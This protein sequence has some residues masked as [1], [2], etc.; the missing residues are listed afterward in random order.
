MIADRQVADK[1]I[2]NSFVKDFILVL[3]K[4]K[5]RYIL[6]SGFVAISHGRSRGTEDIDL[7]IEKISEKRFDELNSALIKAGFECLQGKNALN[8]FNDYLTDNSSIRYVREGAFVPEMELKFAKDPLDE[9]QLKNRVKLPLTGLPFWFSSIE[10]NIAFKEELLKSE[11]DMED[12][13]HLRLIYSEKLD[14]NEINKLKRLIR[15]HR[16]GKS[17]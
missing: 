17:N 2:L 5:I 3:D 12:A 1:S 16:L 15:T 8:L 10:T 13:R 9:N 7:I 4:Q 6:V 14:E 11:K